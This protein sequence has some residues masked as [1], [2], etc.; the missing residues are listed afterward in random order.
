MKHITQKTSVGRLIMQR[1]FCLANEF[2]SPLGKIIQEG[3]AHRAK[4]GKG[5]RLIPRNLALAHTIRYAVKGD[6]PNLFIDPALILLSDGHV[7]EI[8]IRKTQRM[9]SN[10]SVSFDGGTLTKMNHDDE[11]QLVAYHV[12]GR[13]A[14]RSHRTVNRSKKLISLSLPDYLMQVQ[15]LHLYILV[16]DRDGICYSRSQYVGVV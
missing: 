7:K 5:K 11:I 8:N 1:K 14:V 13:V 12:E 9:G 6:F 2:L 15:Q 3:F 4:Q 10:V 16:C